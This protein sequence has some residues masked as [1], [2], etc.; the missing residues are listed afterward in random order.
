MLPISDYLR[1]SLPTYHSSWRHRLTLSEVHKN[2][3]FS[4]AFLAGFS[5]LQRGR[6]RSEVE[7][8]FGGRRRPTHRMRVLTTVMCTVFSRWSVVEACW[9]H[10]LQ[11]RAS[12]AQL[13]KEEVRQ[14]KGLSPVHKLRQWGFLAWCSTQLNSNSTLKF[15]SISQQNFGLFV[16]SLRFSL[17]VF[18]S[19]SN[20]GLTD[21]LS[22]AAAAAGT[23]K[24]NQYSV[25]VLNSCSPISCPYLP[26]PPLEH[27]T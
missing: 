4:L 8:S 5:F 27:I 22:A 10:L 7:V 19:V 1:S 25:N 12:T 14:Y 17:S 13:P 9:T 2:V 6:R 23:K 3:S 21:C 18:D 16:A 11:A 15:N 24:C 20:L 26:P